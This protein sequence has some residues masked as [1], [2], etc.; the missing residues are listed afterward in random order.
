M[1]VGTR[2]LSVD[3][4]T[5]MNAARRLLL[6]GNSSGDDD[7]GYDHQLLAQRLL[8]DDV[9]NGTS[10]PC[11]ELVR[12]HLSG[13]LT[14]VMDTHALNNC[15][16]WRAVVLEAIESNNL[17]GLHGHDDFLLSGTDLLR[18]LRSKSALSALA[19]SPGKFWLQ[20]FMGTW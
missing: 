7:Y 10:D 12:M 8:H 18:V 11:R 5:S 1:I 15:L 16:H 9:W 4:S 13:G 6:S 17:T 14:S 3:A 19:T 20:L 2:L